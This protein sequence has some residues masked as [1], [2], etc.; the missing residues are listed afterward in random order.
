MTIYLVNS[1]FEAAKAATAEKSLRAALPDLTQ[2][3]T[4]DDLGARLAPTGGDPA[5]VL[6]L[7]ALRDDARFERIVE[8]VAEFAGRAFFIVICDEMSASQYKALV[9]TGNADWVSADADP[10]EV[11]EIVARARR[12]ADLAPA[13]GTGGRAAAVLF[14]ASAGGV[15][16]ATLAVETAVH[17]KTAK[18]TRQRNVC[19]V[20]LDFQGSHVCDHLDIEPRLQIGEISTN[21]DRLDAQL[22]EIFASRH[23]SGV[24]VFA[25]PRGRFDAC[26]LNI[27]ALDRLFDMMIARYD[28]ILID[29]PPT[30]FAWTPPILAACSGAIVTGLNTIPALRRAAET[31]A[32]VRLNASP[33]ARLAVAINRTQRGLMGGVARRQHVETVLARETIFYVSEQPALLDSINAGTPAIAA[34][35]SRS[36]TR[37]IGQLAGFC[38]G[39]LPAAAAKPSA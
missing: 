6:L 26:E 33:S 5:V 39:L 19:I 34:G 18:A 36:W 4:I 28:L 31:L 7:A 32:T 8:A 15:G 16:N 2:L 21:P 22:F 11:L 35:A 30:W 13:G 17:V 27:A 24:H 25:A 1:G 23:A 29:L 10:R 37:E 12:G 14:A 3:A 9:R 20:D 38:A